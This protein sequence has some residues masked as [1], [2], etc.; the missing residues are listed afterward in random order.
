MRL[1][2]DPNYRV[3]PAV[4]AAQTTADP[5]APETLPEDGPA[6]PALEATPDNI[7][8]LIWVRGH[9]HRVLPQTKNQAE[10]QEI[11]RLLR[12]IQDDVNSLLKA[13]K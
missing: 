11:V 7:Q 9:L 5:P 10:K 8:R 12:L 3:E 2:R 13:L 1:L 6:I 4:K